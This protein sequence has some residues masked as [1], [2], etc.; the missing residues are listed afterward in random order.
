LILLFRLL[1]LSY[2]EDSFRKPCPLLVPTNYLSCLLG[3]NYNYTCNSTIQKYS[4]CGEIL[5]CVRM[6]DFQKIRDSKRKKVNLCSTFQTW[7]NNSPIW[8]EQFPSLISLLLLACELALCIVL[9]FFPIDKVLN[10]IWRDVCCF[11][12]VCSKFEIDN[13]YQLHVCKNSE[14]RMLHYALNPLQSLCIQIQIQSQWH[15]PC[16]SSWKLIKVHRKRNSELKNNMKA[17]NEM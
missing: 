3:Q 15:I 5:C 7:R 10:S 16:L 13:P 12:F 1:Y 11:N 4:N 9:L 6:W 8:I 14:M 17:A 2:Q